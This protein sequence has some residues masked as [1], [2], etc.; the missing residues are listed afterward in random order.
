MERS[1]P[2][3]HGFPHGDA[4]WSVAWLPAVAAVVRRQEPHDERGAGWST[5]CWV[6]DEA[7][8]TSSSFVE[9]SYADASPE[10]YCLWLGVR[11]TPDESGTGRGTHGRRRA[12]WS[13]FRPPVARDIGP[14]APARRPGETRHGRRRRA[15]GSRDVTGEAAAILCGAPPSTR[16]A[17]IRATPP[18]ASAHALVFKLFRRVQPGEN[19]EV[20]VARFLTTRTAFRDFSSLHGS[21]SYVAAHGSVSTIGVLQTWVD[22]SPTAGA[23]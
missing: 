16:L 20:E 7:A 5:S 10:R 17:P 6:R 9:V 21:V 19:P 3:P 4:A 22:N 18:S 11:D 14:A 1:T 8:R 13:T 12:G 2:R 23:T 15:C